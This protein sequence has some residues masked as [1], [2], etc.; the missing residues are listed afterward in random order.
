MRVSV[1]QW[2]HMEKVQVSELASKLASGAAN[3]FRTFV[4]TAE[5]NS[6]KMVII[7]TT[8][9]GSPAMDLEKLS[10]VWSFASVTHAGK[11]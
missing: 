7:F 2:E 11:L 10:R 4:C 6:G 1:Q 9:L 3:A 8:N 5:P